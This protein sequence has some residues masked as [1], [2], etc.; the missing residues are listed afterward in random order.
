ME[1]VNISN[2]II[3]KKLDSCVDYMIMRKCENIML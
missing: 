1:L 3:R 2:N